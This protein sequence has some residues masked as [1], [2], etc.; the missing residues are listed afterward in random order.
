MN[1]VDLK[2]LLSSAR[3][4]AYDASS[5]AQSA[6]SYGSDAESSAD[7]ANEK[8]EEIIDALDNEIQYNDDNLKALSRTGVMLARL[9]ALVVDRI[10]DEVRGNQVS[11]AEIRTY[12]SIRSIIYKT[13]S[14]NDNG[15]FTGIDETASIEYDY[16]TGNYVVGQKE[17]TNE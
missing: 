9:S 6:G 17:T 7:R 11:Q 8:L 2:E 15:G 3:S 13:F 16:N 1:I 4:Y 5:A 10:D 12:E 14:Q